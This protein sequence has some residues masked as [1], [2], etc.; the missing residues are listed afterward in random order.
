LHDTARKAISEN[1]VTIR[2]GKRGIAKVLEGR[3][4]I[5]KA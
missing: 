5:G 1:I 3:V 4:Y 2:A